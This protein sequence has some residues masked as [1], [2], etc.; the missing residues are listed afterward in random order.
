MAKIDSYQTIASTVHDVFG[1]APV[2]VV[3]QIQAAVEDKTLNPDQF[4]SFRRTLQVLVTEFTDLH[5]SIGC[6]QII[7][8][9]LGWHELIDTHLTY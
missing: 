8:E 4:E 1:R 6:A 5:T 2:Q 7:Y 3:D 9:N